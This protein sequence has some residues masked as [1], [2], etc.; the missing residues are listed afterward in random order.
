M[1]VSGEKWRG[2][3]VILFTHQE[4]VRD[5]VKLKVCVLRR[6]RL[7]VDYLCDDLQMRDYHYPPHSL[8]VSLSF[9]LVLSSTLPP[10]VSVSISCSAGSFADLHI[11]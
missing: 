10:S 11:H 3:I 5:E 2:E 8:E 7:C 9:I 6:C 4:L 1:V